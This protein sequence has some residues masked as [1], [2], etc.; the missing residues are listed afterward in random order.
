MVICEL[1]PTVDVAMG[2][3]A[4]VCPPATN[5]VAATRAMVLLLLASCTATPPDGAALVSVTVPDTS[6]C[7]YT[8][9]ALRATVAS[10]SDP[11]FGAGCAGVDGAGEGEGEGEPVGLGELGV[12]PPHPVSSITKLIARNGRPRRTARRIETSM[13]GMPSGRAIALPYANPCA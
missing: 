8:E 7:P 2:N 13:A 5:T 10:A 3:D 11:G 4:L 12:P 1:F 9:E 6:A